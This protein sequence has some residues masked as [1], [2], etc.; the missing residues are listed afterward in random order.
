MCGCVEP[1]NDK[2]YF[3]LCISIEAIKISSKYA[4][5]PSIDLSGVELNKDL[6][7]V[8]YE[9]PARPKKNWFS[10]TFFSVVELSG[11]SAT[12]G[13][14]PPSYLKTWIFP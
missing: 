9:D 12:E 14:A 2:K 13:A 1:N 7:S 3:L 4:S 5:P 8:C 11:G 6:E 10:R